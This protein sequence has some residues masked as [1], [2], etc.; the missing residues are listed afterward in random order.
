[1]TRLAFSTAVGTMALIGGACFA[2]S[3]SGTKPADDRHPVAVAV[4]A[5]AGVV[6]GSDQNS[7]EFIWRLL[8]QFAAPVNPTQPS[9]VVFETWA[10][11]ADV[12]SNTPRWPGPDAPKKFQRMVTIQAG[13][14]DAPFVV[15]AGDSRCVRA[16]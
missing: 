10:S 3:S 16:G 12:F 5:R 4:P 8:A 15:S 11:D 7:D 2:T 13:H 6:T 14:I 9:P 1:M